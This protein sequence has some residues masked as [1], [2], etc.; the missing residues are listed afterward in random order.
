VFI[1]GKGEIAPGNGG[2]SGVPVGQGKT[3]ERE[4]REESEEPEVVRLLNPQAVPQIG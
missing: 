1:G 4:D 2:E 3:V